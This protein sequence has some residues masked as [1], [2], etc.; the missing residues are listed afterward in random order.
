[1]KKSTLITLCFVC[2]ITTPAVIVLG[3]VPLQTQG[4]S[5]HVRMQATS[6][7]VHAG[8]KQFDGRWWAGASYEEKDGYISGHED[9]YGSGAKGP[10]N[11]KGWTGRDYMNA[12]DAYYRSHSE[13]A[14]AAVGLVLETIDRTAKS[15]PL[16]KGGEI[17]KE[18]HGYYDGQFWREAS[19]N[20]R[21]GYLEGYLLCYSKMM[22]GARVKFS[23]TPSKYR[24][25]INEYVESHPKSDDEKLAYILYRFRDRALAR[26]K[27]AN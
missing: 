24:T 15:R 17:W 26:P 21:L 19:E 1:M 10:R 20:E 8:G 9:C 14:N 6:K 23:D 3:A 4:L 2:Y 25:L 27:S 13:N 22:N 16:P 7:D 12:V 18:P 5:Q 11:T